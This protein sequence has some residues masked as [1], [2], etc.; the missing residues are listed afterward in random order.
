[1]VCKIGLG[2][3][4]CGTEPAPVMKVDASK[5]VDEAPRKPKKGL[6]RY[7]PAP[8]RP[9]TPINQIDAALSQDEAELHAAVKQ[10]KFMDAHRLLGQAVDPNARDKDNKHKTPIY[11]A[12]SSDVLGLLI[13]FGAKLNV[14]DDDGKAPEPPVKATPM[15][16][17]LVH[18]QYL[19]GE[20]G[21]MTLRLP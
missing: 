17:M 20:H 12:T 9:S 3:H 14:V 16:Q 6:R 13:L 19:L 8:S 2:G 15:Q 1:M 18:P 10:D 11:F 7:E 5:A 21:F 4:W